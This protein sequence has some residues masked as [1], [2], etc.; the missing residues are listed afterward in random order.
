VWTQTEIL[1]ATVPAYLIYFGWA[2]AVF[3]GSPSWIA[4]GA[5]AYGNTGAEG[6]V[7][8]FSGPNIAPLEDPTIVTLTFKGQKVYA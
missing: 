2:T 1:T 8:F 6:A 7:Y 4:I 3:A 5:P